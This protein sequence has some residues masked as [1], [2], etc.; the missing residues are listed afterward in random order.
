MA[1]VTW[2]KRDSD[3]RQ[4]GDTSGQ[5]AIPDVSKSEDIVGPSTEEVADTAHDE[6]DDL[7]KEPHVV[8]D[9]PDP[10]DPDLPTDMSER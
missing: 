6:T 9:Q 8:S 2:W 1:D 4:R 3:D 7:S 10:D 5:P